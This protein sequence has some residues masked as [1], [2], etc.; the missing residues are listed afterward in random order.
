METVN[1]VYMAVSGAPEYTDEHAKNV[2]NLSLEFTEY[3][4]DLQSPSGI[5]IQVKIGM[6]VYLFFYY[7]ILH[8]VRYLFFYV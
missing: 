2:T 8:N 1:Q 5:Q 3:I 6:I 7:L 4:R